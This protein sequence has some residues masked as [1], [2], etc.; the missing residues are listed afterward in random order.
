M[1]TDKAP[2]KVGVV[3]VGRGSNFAAGATDL[4]GM[5]LVALVVYIMIGN[6]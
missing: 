2:I 3:G 1:S 6:I 4:V 5:K